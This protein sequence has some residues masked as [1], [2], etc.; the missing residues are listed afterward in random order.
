M[1][2]EHRMCTFFRFYLCPICNQRPYL[3]R[4]IHFHIA[5]WFI[6]CDNDYTVP[7]RPD[8]SPSALTYNRMRKRQHV[9]SSR[10]HG[11]FQDSS[12][13]R[14]S[15]SRHG[16]CF[17]LP[18]THKNHKKPRRFQAGRLKRAAMMFQG[19]KLR[20]CFQEEI[21]MQNRVYFGKEN[22]KS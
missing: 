20:V 4:M 15:R 14:L 9:L 19:P 8:R 1:L 7:C 12:V 5:L 10:S 22:V 11:L 17:L 6:K 2:A 16:R 18:W 13:S 21:A 3:D